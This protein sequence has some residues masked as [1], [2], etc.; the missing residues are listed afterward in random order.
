MDMDSNT[1]GVD[2]PLPIIDFGKFYGSIED[3]RNVAAEIGT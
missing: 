1:N 2:T 3:R